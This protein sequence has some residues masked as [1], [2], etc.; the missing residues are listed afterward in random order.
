MLTVSAVPVPR[1]RPRPA[2]L[3][4][5]CRYYHCTCR[6][7]LPADNGALKPGVW[8]CTSLEADHKWGFA[9]KRQAEETFERL[10]RCLQTAERFTATTPAD[11]R[12]ARRSGDV[13][14]RG[15]RLDGGSLS[16][17]NVGNNARALGTPLRR[18]AR[19][20]SRERGGAHRS[21]QIASENP[22]AVTST[23]RTANSTV[24]GSEGRRG[25]RLR[26][27]DWS[28]TGHCDRCCDDGVADTSPRTFQDGKESPRR[29]YSRAR[30][31]RR[32]RAREG[33]RERGLVDGSKPL[34]VQVLLA[35]LLAMVAFC[36]ARKMSELRAF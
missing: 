4:C 27:N 12:H 28:G 36:A 26:R 29:G 10:A 24:S 14:H 13:H 18:S 34:F 2:P 31:G 16:W 23:T 6:V 30:S 15:D 19:I 33:S 9:S 17:H 1:S 32:R 25:L 5:C 11:D 8:Y 22:A 35:L 20:L 7:D 3:V 21:E